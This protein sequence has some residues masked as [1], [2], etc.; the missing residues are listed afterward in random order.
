MAYFSSSQPPDGASIKRRRTDRF[1]PGIGL[2]RAA[3]SIGVQLA[4]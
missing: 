1:S 4:L 2:E 3:A